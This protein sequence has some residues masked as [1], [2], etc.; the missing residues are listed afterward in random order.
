MITNAIEPRGFQVIDVENHCLVRSGCQQT[1]REPSLIERAQM[2]DLFAV[3]CEPPV[4]VG[5]QMLPDTTDT[6]VGLDHVDRLTT[7]DQFDLQVV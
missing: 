5:I 1:I 6:Y 2:K 3:Q 4:S 7:Q